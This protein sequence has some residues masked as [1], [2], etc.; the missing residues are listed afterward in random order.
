MPMVDRIYWISP[1]GWYHLLVFGIFVPALSIRSLRVVRKSPQVLP[2]RIKHFRTT[3]IVL[4]VFLALSL[5]TASQQ[6]VDL[7][8]ADWTSAAK[9]LPAGLAMYFVAVLGMRPRWRKAVVERKPIVR[10]FMP[11]NATERTWWILV[12]LLAGISEEITWR[13]MQTML[14]EAVF[15]SIAVAVILCAILFGLGHAVQGW[16]SI[17]IVAA[18]ALGFHGLVYMSGSL[19]LAMAVHVAYDI[20]AGMSYGR[21]GRAL[22]YETDSNVA[23]RE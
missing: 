17:P 12:A 22:G 11:T 9:A 10:L 1:M 18:F 6:R 3:S 19:Y 7:F 20:T 15:G 13:G 2:E 16:K 23:A 14:L 8:S 21:L 5:F 4:V